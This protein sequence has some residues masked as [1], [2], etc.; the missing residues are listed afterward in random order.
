MNNKIF[1]M[2]FEQKNG[3]VERMH[4]LRGAPHALEVVT[5]YH[6]IHFLQALSLSGDETLNKIVVSKRG[7]KNK[8][9]SRSQFRD[10]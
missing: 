1:N 8:Y 3:D 6:K 2:T 5:C 4:V 10:P 9:Q 7:I